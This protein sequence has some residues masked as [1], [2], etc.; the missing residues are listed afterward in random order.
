MEYDVAFRYRYMY[1]DL[2]KG[3]EL[4]ARLSGTFGSNVENISYSNLTLLASFGIFF[5]CCVNKLKE[6][7]LEVVQ[8]MY[9]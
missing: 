7:H 3:R 1:S 6:K 8:D 5:L 9:F 2:I 4:A